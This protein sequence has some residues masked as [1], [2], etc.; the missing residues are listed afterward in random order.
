MAID[1]DPSQGVTSIGANGH[2][3]QVSPPQG[4]DNSSAGPP[5]V[6]DPVIYR[7]VVGLLGI[8]MVTG[9]CGALILALNG[10]DKPP[11][12]FLALGSAAVGALAGIL[13]PSPDRR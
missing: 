7:M 10:Q 12:I 9:I 8:V 6:C 2:S 3:P 1:S 5:Y 11:D 13:A 4:K